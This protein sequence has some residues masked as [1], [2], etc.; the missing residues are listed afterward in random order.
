MRSVVLSFQILLK[1]H[2]RNTGVVYGSEG[3]R[4]WQAGLEAIV[5]RLAL[6]PLGIY[7]LFVCGLQLLVYEAVRY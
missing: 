7:H 5:H 3:L 4:A 2:Q 1:G 6:L